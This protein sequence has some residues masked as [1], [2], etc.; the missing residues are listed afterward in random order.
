MLRFTFATMFAG[1]TTQLINTYE[2]YRIKG[3][4]PVVIKPAIDDREGYFKGWGTTRS[5]LIDKEIPAYYY[6]DIRVIDNLNFKTLLIDEAQFMTRK[7][8]LYVAQLANKN[9]TVL[10][11]GLKTD[12]NGEL[13]EGSQALLALADELYEM[14]NLCQIHGCTNKAVAHAR[15]IDGVRDYSTNSIAIEKDNV[16]YK[17]VCRKHWMEGL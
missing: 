14:E 15:Y 17:A 5:R 12:S 9:T 11:Y 13:F 8:V 7:D 4:D 1:K 10:A 16:T 2:S 3:L 6:Q